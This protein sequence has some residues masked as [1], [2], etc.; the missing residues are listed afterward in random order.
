MQRGTRNFHS[1]AAPFNGVCA[2]CRHSDAMDHRYS[3][4]MGAREAESILAGK[5]DGTYIIRESETSPGDHNITI[6]DHNMVYHYRIVKTVTGLCVSHRNPFRLSHL[7]IFL[8][9]L[10]ARR[11]TPGICTPKRCLRHCGNW[12]PTIKSTTAPS[13]ITNSQSDCGFRL[14]PTPQ[15]RGITVSAP[16]RYRASRRCLT[17]TCCHRRD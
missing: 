14:V 6:R 13:P 5:V 17:R 3:G 12:S 15:T 10:F 8:R 11:S 9:S 4:K 1:G 7:L 16:S 2:V